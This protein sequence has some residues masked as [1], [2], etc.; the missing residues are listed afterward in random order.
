MRIYSIIAILGLTNGTAG[1]LSALALNSTSAT[2]TWTCLGSAFVMGTVPMAWGLLKLR[3]SL[4]ALETR[5]ASTDSNQ[6]NTG[7]VELD[8][9]GTSFTD[10]LNE[11]KR[12]S[13]SESN[14][15][16]EMKK[17]LARMDR[18]HG[19]FSREGGETD[20]V[21]QL[22]SI[23]QGCG[24]ELDSN[25]RQAISCGREIHKA[26]EEIVS[27]SEA[28]SDSVNRTTD[29]IEQLST[30]I[31]SVCDTA[32]EALESSATAQ[33]TAKS[34][35]EQFKILVD[36]MK[37]IRNHAAARERKLQTLGQHTKEIES[38]VQ[39]IG[40]LSS[41]TDLL[42][43]NASIESVRAGEHGRGFAVVADE[44]RALAEQSA[45]AVLDITRRIEMIQLETRQSISVASGEHDQMHDVIKKVNETHE[46][47]Q[48]ICN[49]AVSS[50]N[51]LTAIADSTQQQLQITREIIVALE[52][53]TETSRKNR[54]RA[55]GANWTAKTL[56]QIGGQ[57]D[58]S[59]DVLRL[60]GAMQ[61]ADASPPSQSPRQTPI[62]SASLPV[63][64]PALA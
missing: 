50:G 22:R 9:I 40:T 5:S 11:A 64:V 46:S 18:R 12:V 57:L 29:F 52:R 60:S 15:L 20:C 39:T 14:E 4:R 26:T 45:Q 56:Q 42:A 37:Q 13:S 43:L 55:E 32:E 49:A 27:G 44:V 23:L 35:L 8:K 54:S 30:R 21:T 41:R 3:K 36:E 53:S 51:G 6:K 31:I 34:G 33:T 16:A 59:L 61:S 48:D 58:A 47:L 28:Q 17:L 38:I 19:E 7:I 25:L 63:E 10:S 2:M 62:E 1:S 24:N